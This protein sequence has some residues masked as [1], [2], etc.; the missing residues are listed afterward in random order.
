[1]KA[2]QELR[3]EVLECLEDVEYL[4]SPTGK[5]SNAVAHKNINNARKSLEDEIFRIAFIATMSTG[6]STL[7]NAMLGD[8]LL[9]TAN[10]ASTAR[11]TYITHSDTEKRLRVVY[12]DDTAP[13]II[14]QENE[15][16]DAIKALMQ[17]PVVDNIERFELSYPIPSL[18]NKIPK[19]IQFVDTPGP[20]KAGATEHQRVTFEFID[21]ANVIIYILDYTKRGIH[22]DK[23]ILEE[24]KER[25]KYIDQETTNKFFF[26]LNKIDLRKERHDPPL[27]QII[28][29]TQ[30]EL[31]SKYGFNQPKV[32]AVSAERALLSR[33]KRSKKLSGQIKQDYA[34]HR[35]SIFR[36]AYDLD[37]FEDREQ[38]SDQMLSEVGEEMLK[39]SRICE[40]EKAISDYLIENRGWQMLDDILGET[41]T[42]IIRIVVQLQEQKVLWGIE[43]EQLQETIKEINHLI[44][45]AKQE[46]QQ[47]LPELIERHKSIMKGTLRDHIFSYE[48]G[49]NFIIDEML[50]SEKE[51]KRSG[52]SSIFKDEL[53][54]AHSEK[55]L[56]EK[57]DTLHHTYQERCAGQWLDLEIHLRNVAHEEGGNVVATLKREVNHLYAGVQEKIGRKL[58]IE[59][60]VIPEIIPNNWRNGVST[61]DISRIF[62]RVDKRITTDRSFFHKFLQFIT[63]GATGAPRKE[64]YSIPKYRIK[65]FYR[66]FIGKYS[67]ETWFLVEKLIDNSFTKIG[68]SSLT[69]IDDLNDLE[70]RLDNE[71]GK[72]INQREQKAKRLE[73]LDTQLKTINSRKDRIEQLRTIVNSRFKHVDYV[74]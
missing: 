19:G 2:Y 6:K 58:G 30:E 31:Q 40:L 53:L 43:I 63:F 1:M 55:E 8:E 65:D 10:E 69:L 64:I 42:E 34:I 3:A 17:E 67:Q 12:R 36:E 23:S 49:L 52:L 29:K 9:F 16:F 45:E 32:Y 21:K 41:F 5:F 33:M 28:T 48:D 54:I 47:C 72:V 4:F 70:K 46:A 60:I 20:N 26:L 38:I 37:P 22:D 44:D 11:L 50:K 73:E 51:G 35:D 25:R 57:I 56:Q 27:E 7:L 14:Q 61:P 18:S 62:E 74:E 15:I 13:K 59:S 39:R 66:D 68:H 24:I 71:Y